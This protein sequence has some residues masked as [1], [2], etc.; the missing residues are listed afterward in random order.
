MAVQISKIHSLILE[1]SSCQD[2]LSR[3]LVKTRIISVL[4]RS[5]GNQ[6]NSS[7]K[8]GTRNYIRRRSCWK[9]R[10]RKSITFGIRA[11]FKSLAQKILGSSVGTLTEDSYVFDRNSHVGDRKSQVVNRKSH[12]VHG[13][14]GN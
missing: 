10:R 4:T 1:L 2:F 13:N 3:F 5:S 14:R 9:T 8:D 7:G 6:R 11:L 12:I